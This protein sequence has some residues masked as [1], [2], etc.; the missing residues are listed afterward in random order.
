MDTPSVRWYA[1][2]LL[3]GSEVQSPSA[4][5]SPVDHQVRLIAAADSEAAYQRALSL[6]KSEEHSYENAFGQIVRWRFLGLHDLVEFL[7]PPSEGSEVFSFMASKGTAWLPLP[8]EKLT[9][10]RLATERETPTDELIR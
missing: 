8:K 4:D 7:A 9:V 3:L 5:E 1:A 10:F 6:G 2:V